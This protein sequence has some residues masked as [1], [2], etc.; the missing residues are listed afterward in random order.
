MANFG[1]F[2]KEIDATTLEEPLKLLDLIDRIGYYHETGLTRTEAGA[3][4]VHTT[5]HLRKLGQKAR[6]KPLNQTMRHTHYHLVAFIGKEMLQRAIILYTTSGGS[7]DQSYAVAI[8]SELIE[9]Y[10]R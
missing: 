1:Q 7:A 9:D 6:R 10:K 4:Y 8:I 2:C 5:N 3:L